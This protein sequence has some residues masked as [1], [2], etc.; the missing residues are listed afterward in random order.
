MT[1]A[2][3][4]GFARANGEVDGR[5]WA[6]EVKSVNGRGLDLRFRLP[7]GWDHLEVECRKEAAARLARGSVTANLQ[8]EEPSRAGTMLINEAALEDAIRAIE[9][10]RTQIE[11]APPRAEGILALRG[12]LEPGGAVA[13]EAARE[14]LDV[15]IKRGF[16]A[17]LD[18]L[19][20]ARRSEGAE[21]R[22]ALLVH[23][24]AAARLIED[25]RQSAEAAPTAIRD[26]LQRQIAE[27]IAGAVTEE[28]LAV[29]A[30]L[31]AVKADIREELDRLG[32]HLA[33]VRA[34]IESGE[35]AGRRLDFLSQELNREANTLCSKAQDIG[36][37]RIGLDLKTAIDQFRE[38]VQN[39]E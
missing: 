1:V 35:P 21:I 33:A 18:G 28:R 39:V 15:A 27:L 5:R 36:L 3:M 37:K 19:V 26:R 2:S 13:D 34:L 12:V 16:G 20:A 31:L 24:D 23:M 4:T 8:L 7:P 9:R 6:W 14:K 30:A 10:I 22:R 32:A 11:C 17:A 25:A 29:E 38:Q